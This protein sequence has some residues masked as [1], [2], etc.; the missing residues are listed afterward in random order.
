MGKRTAETKTFEDVIKLAEDL[1]EY[2]C[3]KQEKIDE[4]SAPES[5]DSEFQADKQEEVT[6]TTSDGEKGDA[7]EDLFT[8]D[9]PTKRPQ[10]REVD[11]DL[12]TP[13]YTSDAPKI[14]GT[15]GGEQFPMDETESVTDAALQESLETLIDD[16]AKE[17]IYL[18]LPKID[19]KE[20]IQPHDQVQKDLQ[21]WYYEENILQ[22]IM[23]N[24]S[25]Q[26]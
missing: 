8:D 18:N 9:D 7:E 17:W 2:A 16:N 3:K 4:I 25:K 24:I 23:L 11:P 20:I 26:Y 12:E 21:E 10:E 6:P 19:L 22:K 15:M 5:D 13:S 1:Y 14:G